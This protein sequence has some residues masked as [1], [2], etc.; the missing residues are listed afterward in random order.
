MDVMTIVLIALV[1]LLIGISKSAFAGALGVFA[2]PLLMLKLPATEAIA[3][4]LPLLII[5]DILSV[6]S[7]WKKWDHRLLLSL[8]PGAFIGVCVAYFIIDYINSEHLRL[9]IG[10]ICISFS[11]KNLFL[12]QTILTVLNNKV[13]GLI[14]SVFS[15]MTS[16]LVHAGGPPIIIY[17]SAIG[18]APHKF[19]AT[20]SAFFAMMNILKLIGATSLGVLTS[21]IIF[22]A[23]VFIPLA[24]IGNWIGVRIIKSLNKLLFLKIMNYLLLLLGFSLLFTA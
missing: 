4:M 21:E 12:K 20:A 7:Y 2:V 9:I 13:G 19:I 16:T 8:I 11:L 15:G 23:I 17:F 18:L 14:M 1:V 6:R 22:T 3:L 24:F 5:G 10:I